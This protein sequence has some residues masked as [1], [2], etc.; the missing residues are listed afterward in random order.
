[1][2]GVANLL[3]FSV[4]AA[5]F[6][7]ALHGMIQIDTPLLFLILPF[8]LLGINWGLSNAGM[9]TA[10]NQVITPRKIGAAIGTIATIWNVVGSIILA[11]SAAVFHAEQIQTSFL[12]AFHS[13]V[14]FNIG[15][16]GILLGFTIWVRMRLPKRS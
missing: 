4:L 11:T 10:V 5:F 9:I 6:A 7:V 12:P 3:F 16:A 15:F 8:F 1:M 13:T 14:Y 2:F